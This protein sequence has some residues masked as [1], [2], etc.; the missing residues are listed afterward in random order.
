MPKIQVRWF[1][2]L[3]DHTGVSTEQVEVK[4]GQTVEQLWQDCEQR[5]PGLSGLSFRPAAALDLEY[6]SWSSSLDGIRE[7]A[8]LPP[9]SGG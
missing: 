7:L 1:A 3:V 2:S 8:F 5:Y 6:A 9:V 4:E